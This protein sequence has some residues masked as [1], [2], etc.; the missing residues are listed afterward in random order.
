MDIEEPAVHLTSTD[1][2][3]ILIDHDNGYPSPMIAKRSKVN[4]QQ[5][6]AIIDAARQ[7]ASICS[8]KGR[9]RLITQRRRKRFSGADAEP[10]S[11]SPPT[12]E[13][14]LRLAVLMIERLRP[15]LPRKGALGDIGPAIEHFLNHV[16]ANNSGV[17]FYRPEDATLF[18]A[19][20]AE[21][22]DDHHMVFGT[23][24]PSN[25]SRLTAVEQRLRWEKRLGICVRPDDKRA[26]L[27]RDGGRYGKLTV[28]LKLPNEQGRLTSAHAYKYV[29]H[30]AA[31]ALLSHQ[32]IQLSEPRQPAGATNAGITG[33]PGV[34]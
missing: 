26:P 14:D 3:R 20:L 18:V 12:S 15:L 33:A 23:H 4:E 1:I 13:S 2:E 24:V 32:R 5:C 6:E 27:K 30:L 29:L 22:A 10:L 28:S 17:R 9:P 19:L 16:E 21:I 34:N 7:V 25:T 11:P 31:I 8:N